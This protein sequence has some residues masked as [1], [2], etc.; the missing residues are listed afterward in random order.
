M[1]V[2]AVSNVKMRHHDVFNCFTLQLKVIIR[3]VK[4]EVAQST[5]KHLLRYFVYQVMQI[6]FNVLRDLGT[7]RLLSI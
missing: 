5:D 3:P 1:V 6:F 4:V 2:I 7:L